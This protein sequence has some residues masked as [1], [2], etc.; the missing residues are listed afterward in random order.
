MALA[1]LFHELFHGAEHGW[2]PQRGKALMS[3]SACD[4]ARKQLPLSC[5][6]LLYPQAFSASSWKNPAEFREAKDQGHSAVLMWE[7]FC[8]AHFWGMGQGEGEGK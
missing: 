8:R 4:S 2:V 3:H 7:V 1:E 5:N 6:K